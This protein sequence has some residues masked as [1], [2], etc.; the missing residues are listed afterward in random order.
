MP[1]PLPKLD[2]RS[3]HDLVT[4]GRALIPR[5]APAW[6]DHNIHDPG[7]TL[8]ELFA[9]LTEMNVYKLDRTRSASYRGFLRRMGVEL[10]PA[11]AAE[12]TVVFDEEPPQAGLALPAGIQLESVLS[13]VRFQTTEPLFVSPARLVSL[14]AGTEAKWVENIGENV[15]DGAQFFPFGDTPLTGSALTFGF[16]RPLGPVG[17]SISL[18][19][20]TGRGEG[21]RDEKAALIREWERAKAEA[22]V[23]CP[24]G[25]E[26]DLPSWTLHYSV[27][28]I[29]E[30]WAGD[31]L[32]WRPLEVGVDET[33]ALTLSGAIRFVVPPDHVAH[34]VA[35]PLYFVRCRMLSGSFECPVGIE[36]LML[37]GV[38][39]KHAAD[40]DAELSLGTSNGRACQSFV[41][42]KELRPILPGS[43]E[44]RVLEGAIEKDTWREARFWDE[45]GAH[46]RV[47]LLDPELGT[48]T[49]GDGRVG[50]VPPTDSELRLRLQL[51]GGAS[52]NVEA[53]TLSIPSLKSHNTNLVPGWDA[54]AATL[55]L[56][57]PEDAHGGA[58]AESLASGQARA[59]RML[60]AP[61]RAITLAD[62]E[63]VALETPG[64]AVG[65]VRA[66]A[67][68][69]PMLGCTNA[70][71]CVSLVVIPDCPGPRP[72][73]GPDFLRAVQ[74]YV[75]RR[76][77][78]ATEVHVVPPRYTKVSIRARLHVENDVDEAALVTLALAELARFFNPLVGGPDGTGWP[79]GRAVYRAEVMALL[80]TLPDVLHVDQ[81]GILADSE[82]AP[83][84][85]NLGLC[86]DGLVESGA[87]SIRIIS[88][89]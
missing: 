62:F 26:P 64:V 32:G 7:I 88:K 46:D 13:E 4:E 1:L 60:A 53:S 51:G 75:D 28:T 47:Y 81:F 84:C 87:H 80:S 38:I 37:N 45:V 29:W 79:A 59:L 19:L 50:F 68:L 73:P 39:A 20:W 52:G 89:D 31:A 22:E 30:Y 10:Q 67:G 11:L 15:I 43:T 25:V 33:R 65:R 85:Q 69:H 6:T 76:R 70:L 24:P 71:G 72:M 5:R 23:S 55:V 48:I 8:L 61:D 2:N 86:A 9:W 16:D 57:Q 42:P 18:W 35:P 74:R 78:V 83:R 40:V 58:D 17:E 36:R 54:I 63:A 27:S 41:V 34:E 49:T 12:T 82:D 21:D 3:Y 66:V 44:L 77:T 56:K 14:R